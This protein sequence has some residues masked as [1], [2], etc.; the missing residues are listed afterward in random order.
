MKK[1]LLAT[2]A[3]TAALAA[4]QERAPEVGEYRLLLANDSVPPVTLRLE[5]PCTYALV[6]AFLRTEAPNY[7]TSFD[8]VHVCPTGVRPL[9]AP[10]VEGTFRTRGDSIFFRDTGGNDAGRGTIRGD[11]ITV[12]GPEHVLTFLRAGE[13][14]R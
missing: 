7:Y 9:N 4:C 1:L 10:V 8:I 13:H 11:T 12:A 3:A 5:S 6:D 14:P 2:A